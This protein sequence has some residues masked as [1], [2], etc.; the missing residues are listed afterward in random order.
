MSE[1]QKETYKKWKD[2]VNMSASELKRFMDSDEG[3]KA[4]LSRKEAKQLGIHYGRESARWILKMKDTPVSEWTPKM[5][6][7][8]NRQISFNSRM[9]GNKGKLYDDKGR[10]T[11][12]HLS[13]LIWGHN[14]EKYSEGGLIIDDNIK[15]FGL[16]NYTKSKKSGKFYKLYAE[17]KINDKETENWW[18][19]FTIQDGK[20]TLGILRYR[21]ENEEKDI[22]NEKLISLS[23]LPKS[24]LE[25]YNKFENGGE[26]EFQ[27][28]SEKYFEYVPISEIEKYKELEEKLGGIGASKKTAKLIVTDLKQ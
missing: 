28:K 7:W 23:D 3:K 10:K 9:R 14:P 11:R 22:Y 24:L 21:F 1:S 27:S 2:L 20:K 13:L 5:W 12:K 19:N 16:N 6:E 18:I 25:V 8:A 26:I 4:G 15:V 17:R